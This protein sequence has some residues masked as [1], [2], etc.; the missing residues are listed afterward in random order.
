VNLAVF[1]AQIIGDTFFGPSIMSR[2]VPQI[3]SDADVVTIE[4]GIPDMGFNGATPQTAQRLLPLVAAVRARAPRA[5]LVFLGLRCPI[6]CVP[7][8]VDAWNTTERRLARS[9]DVWIATAPFG[10]IHASSAIPDGGHPSLA[11]AER[12]GN[13]VAARIRPWF[14]AGASHS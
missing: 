6:G 11:T 12:I 8:A 7:E 13:A 14:L 2:H 10:P 9:S 3:P 4:V 5:H 1:G